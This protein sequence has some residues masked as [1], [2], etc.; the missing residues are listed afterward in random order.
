MVLCN[1][2]HHKSIIEI[3]GDAMNKKLILMLLLLAVTFTLGCVQPQAAITSQEQVSK[4]VTNISQ[5]T[6][7]V[8]SILE[9]ID[10]KL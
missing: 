4:A 8:G 6:E 10:K 5:G 2:R 1:R 9:D 7:K 3:K